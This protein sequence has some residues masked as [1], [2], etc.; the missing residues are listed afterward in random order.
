MML[1]N[2]KL[3]V[4]LSLLTASKFKIGKL[5]VT[6]YGDTISSPVTE[7]K[8]QKCQ[9]HTKILSLQHV[10]F[11]VN[12]YTYVPQF[13][14]Q[15]NFMY[16]CIWKAKWCKIQETKLASHSTNLLSRSRQISIKLNKISSCSTNFLSRSRRLESSSTK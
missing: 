13:L 2:L 4:I 10:P 5:Y 6:C 8:S 16:H 9:C 12:L 3:Q 1:H 15:N 14:M 7:L 11:C